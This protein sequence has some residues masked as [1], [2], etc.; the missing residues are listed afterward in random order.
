MSLLEVIIQPN[1]ILRQKCADVEKFDK[2]LEKLIL[3]MYETMIENKGVG[4]AAPQIGVLKNLLVITFE[5]RNL[6][7]I[8]PKIIS[9]EGTTY[10]DESCLSC[11]DFS[12]HLERKDKLTIEAKNKKGK[13]ITI[14]VKGFLARIV[15]HEMDHLN[16]ILIIDK[17]P[18]KVESL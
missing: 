4:L 9:A 11:P 8:N 12:I 3:D 15:Q 2:D 6:T 5:E 18:A 1:P 10:D 16:G 17:E 14:K 13:P 7:L